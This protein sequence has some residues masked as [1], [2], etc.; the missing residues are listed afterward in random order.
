M[1]KKL[2][3]KYVWFFHFTWSNGILTRT[4]NFYRLS[5][6][7]DMTKVLLDKECEDKAKELNV[8]KDG[9]VITNFIRMDNCKNFFSEEIEND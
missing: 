6:A 4:G 1:T 8:N 5:N 7:Q 2:K 3:Y 9:I